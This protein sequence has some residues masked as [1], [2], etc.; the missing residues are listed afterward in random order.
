MRLIIGGYAQGKLN[1]VMERYGEKEWY[2]MDGTLE[3]TTV[4]YNKVIVNH[5]H[6]WVR[7]CM[8]NGTRTAA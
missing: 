5:F 8:E 3:M 7:S 4:S 2:V 6:K 1:Y